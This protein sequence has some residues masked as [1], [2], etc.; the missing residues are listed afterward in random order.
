MC[1]SRYARYIGRIGALAVALG[2]GAAVTTGQGIGLARADDADS[3]SD[4]SATSTA[5]ETTTDSTTE[6]TSG[7][8]TPTA[9]ETDSSA[10]PGET[11]PR[12][13]VPEMNVSSSGGALT[14]EHHQAQQA[15]EEPDASDTETAAENETPAPTAEPK[16]DPAPTAA[17]PSHAS[18][19]PIAATT[20]KPESRPE[21]TQRRA[22]VVE[23]AEPAAAE[24]SRSAVPTALST[25][26]APV[27]TPAPDT[28]YADPVQALAAIPGTLVSVA[29]TFV[30]ALLAPF[31]APGPTTPAAPPTLWAVL[32]WVRREF[33]RAFFNQTPSAPAQSVTTSEETP[34]V[35]SGFTD[36]DGDPVTVTSY[37][38]AAHGTVT[39]NAAGQVVYTPDENYSGTDSFT[40]TVS[41]I[42][43]APHVHGLLGLFTNAGHTGTATVSVT[44][45]AV[46]HG[47]T[48]VADTAT[49]AEDT[50]VTV[51]VLANDTDSDTPRASLSVALATSP[52]HGT[53]VV[54]ADGTVTYT[55]GANWYGQDT[56]TYTVTDGT[57][58][59]VGTVT[60]TVTPVND[61]PVAN[62]DTATIVSTTPMFSGNVLDNDTDP[63]ADLLTVTDP[64]VVTTGLGTVQIFANG[65]YAYFPRPS[66]SGVD[67]FSYTVSDPSGATAT[68]TLTITVTLP[69][70]APVGPATI[71]VDV[72][73]FTPVSGNLL[74]D[75]T[76]PNDDPLTAV[77]TGTL[78]YG[79]LVLD[80]G[81][82]EYT[83]AAHNLGNGTFTDSVTLTVSDGRGGTVTTALTFTVTGHNQPFPNPGMISYTTDEDTPLTGNLFDWVHDPDGDWMHVVV[84]RGFQHGT[85]VLDEDTGVFTFTP[86]VD[87]EAGESVDDYIIY[88]FD[89]R[90]QVYRSG[91]FHITVTG[92]GPVST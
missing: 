61:T 74:A 24:V 68:A 83:Y 90:H 49:T 14:S 16:H 39:L 20:P 65:D 58:S 4:T 42:S 59:D 1:E 91:Q 53:A 7:T 32:A 54:N 8:D 2:V 19:E 88:T 72:D 57:L 92:V 55:P 6:T 66:S 73:E 45:T 38:Q 27:V 48:A 78:Q 63:D 85:L 21:P 51:N 80:N 9:A 12:A 10:R 18:T 62:D 36:A 47:P 46:D 52:A 34:V 84:N 5:G 69:N 79:S 64:R 15:D 40:V 26:A 71:N 81:T 89:D 30:A 35:V 41:D 77:V 29:T 28:P 86:H 23:S 13:T 56:F 11:A 70:Y 67:V 31:L 44:V 33:Q 76:D 75:Y 60:V 82:G 87:V 3:A 17:A 25:L 50:P 37:T 22:V 43:G